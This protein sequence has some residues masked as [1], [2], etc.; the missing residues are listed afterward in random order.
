MN[1]LIELQADVADIVIKHLLLICCVFFY[2]YTQRGSQGTRTVTFGGSLVQPHPL[3]A[4]KYLD[5]LLED[6]TCRSLLLL[7]CCRPRLSSVAVC[8]KN[9]NV[10]ASGL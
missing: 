3:Q 10:S 1:E 9:I 5:Y 7:E 8:L 4:L 6:T 2:K